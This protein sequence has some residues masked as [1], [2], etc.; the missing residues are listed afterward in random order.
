VL[1]GFGPF[2][3][4]Y[5]TS[6]R[7]TQLDIG[8]VLTTGS[9]VAL[10]GQMPGGALVDAARSERFVAGLGITAIGV[11]ALA[12]A[13][14]SIFPV[15]EAA[16]VLQAAAAC[17]LGPAIAA[18]SLGLVGHAGM[19]ERVGRNARFASLGTGA[20]AIAMGAIG[21]FISPRAVLFVTAAFVLPALLALSFIR[22]KE[23]DPARA[24]GGIGAEGAGPHPHRPAVSL[25]G[26]VRRRELV[27]FAA[28]AMLFQLANAAMLP[29]MASGVTTRASEWATVVVAACIVVPQVVVAVMA[30]WV[31]RSAQRWGR[32]PLLLVGFAMVPLRAILFA[33][34]TDPYW[35]VAV[36]LL[37]GI[38]ASVLGVM[39]PLVVADVTRGTGRFN[40]SLGIVGTAMGIG[41][42]LSTT[43]A[44]YVS[45]HLGSP[46]AFL[47]LA[48]IAAAGLAL[49]WALMPETR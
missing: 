15:V 12:L 20:A 49:V 5:L 25:V 9:L 29:L 46:V 27:I 19:G 4:V 24:H 11:S 32:R 44:G 6:E 38:T 3:A 43:L 8:L 34:V 1:T 35:L 17:L 10:A 47:G 13:L 36:Q 26:L 7:W 40:L 14:W 37:D 31:G 48:A 33:V 23:I 22:E 2:V 45:D 39:V 41:A 18:I 42:S 16:A 28:C 21:Y 30:P